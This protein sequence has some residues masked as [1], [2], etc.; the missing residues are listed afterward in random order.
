MRAPPRGR[1]SVVPWPS[2][3]AGTSLVSQRPGSVT[4]KVPVLFIVRAVL[5]RL[6]CKPHR[7]KTF[8]LADG[9]AMRM[10]LFATFPPPAAV[11]A[12]G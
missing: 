5:R 8:F 3:V 12:A 10:I 11:P 4:W 2:N 6:G 7:R 1:V 9:T